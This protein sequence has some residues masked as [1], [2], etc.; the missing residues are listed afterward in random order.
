MVTVD[1]KGNFYLNFGGERN[2]PL[3]PQLL[4]IRVAA[5]IRLHPKK[6]VYVRGD[7]KVAYARVVEA[8]ALIQKAGVPSVGLL[9]K[10]LEDDN[11]S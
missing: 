8:M 9:T 11:A 5:V 4:V 1:E 2:T 6:P 10:P 3:D 7:Q